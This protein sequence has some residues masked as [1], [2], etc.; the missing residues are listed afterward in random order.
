ME[1]IDM[2]LQISDTERLTVVFLEHQIRALGKLDWVLNT[3]VEF[4]GN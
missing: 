2:F 4:L 3:R 1:T